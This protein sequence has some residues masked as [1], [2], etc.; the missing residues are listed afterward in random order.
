MFQEMCDSD[1]HS[2]ARAMQRKLERFYDRVKPICVTTLG[3]TA[4]LE[5]PAHYLEIL[6][7]QNAA[8][9]RRNEWDEIYKDL[10][11]GKPEYDLWLDKYEEI[12]KQTGDLPIIDLGCGRGSD[13][14]YLYVRGYSVVSCDLSEEALKRL[15]YF[16][17]KPVTKHFDMLN[18]LPFERDSA[19]IVIADLSLHYF[20]WEDTK[21][22]LNDIRRVLIS[23]GHLLCRMNSIRDKN[24]GAGQGRHI[25]KNYFDFQGR[26]KRFFDKDCLEE[27]FKDWSIE[28]ISEA[29]LHRYGKE[30]ILWEIAVKKAG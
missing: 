2:F 9:I 15:S 18:G 1:S 5:F 23:G 6:N 21:R 13:S 10:G 26:L 24:H 16:I 7:R 14:L 25:E 20:Y 8:A 19:R 11:D 3:S 27:L 22:V 12:L 28:H 17:V 4:C 29:P 30:K